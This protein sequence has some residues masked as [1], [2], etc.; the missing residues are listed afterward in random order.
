[1]RTSE[2]FLIFALLKLRIT[3]WKNVIE[4]CQVEKKMLKAFQRF[5]DVSMQSNWTKPQDIMITFNNADLVT[6]KKDGR[7]RIVINIGHNK[8]RLV[9]GYYFA[10][11][12]TIVY[13]KFVGTHAAYN[14]IDV[15]TIDMFKKQK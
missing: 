1:L 6:C 15:C 5:Y 2:I 13:I 9:A 12:Q 11:S 7:T 4:H 3:K 14:K 8:Y 10:T